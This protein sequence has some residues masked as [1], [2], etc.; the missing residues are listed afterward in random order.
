MVVCN[1]RRARQKWAWTTWVFSRE[2][3]DARTSGRIYLA[4]VKSVMIYGSESWVLTPHMKRVLGGLFH[5][6]ARRLTGRQPRRG[7]EGGWVYPGTE[8][9]MA[10]TGLQEVENYVSC[11]QNTVTQ[12]IATKPIMD[13]CLA[14]K[15]NPGPRAAKRWWE[16]ECLDLAGMRTVARESEHAE[17]GSRRTGR[18]QGRGQ[19]TN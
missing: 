16:Q 13:R 2:G 4:V 19:K 8:D 14:A 3:A 18:R 11:R 17:G 7:Q 1:L 5:R 10:E 15:R 12:Y 6:V 9:A